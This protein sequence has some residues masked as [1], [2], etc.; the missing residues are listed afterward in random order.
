MKERINH[1]R[2]TNLGS[3]GPLFL[4]AAIV[5]YTVIV[6]A[7]YGWADSIS[8]HTDDTLTDFSDNWKIS[9]TDQEVALKHVGKYAGTDGAVTIYNYLPSSLS[10]GENLIFES[11]NVFFKVR[12]G[13]SDVYDYTSKPF[14]LAGRSYGYA[15]H[16]VG[17]GRRQAGV[18][19]EMTI[20]PAYKGAGGISEIRIGSSGT[21]MTRLFARFMPAF[22][23]SIL[24]IILGVTMLYISVGMTRLKTPLVD[25]FRMFSLTAILFGIWSLVESRIPIALTTFPDL[26]RCFTFAML[27]VLPYPAVRAANGWMIKPDPRIN[28]FF[29]GI[30]IF[31]IIFTTIVHILFGIDLWQCRLLIHASLLLAIVVMCMMSINQLIQYQRSHVHNLLREMLWGIIQLDVGCMVIDLIRYAGYGAPEDAARFTRVGF[32]LLMLVL[33]MVYKNEMVTRMK[34]SMEADLYQKLAYRDMMTGFYNRSALLEM[35]EKL[36]KEKEKGHTRDL[37]IVY[38]DLNYLKRVND[39]YGHQAGDDYICRSAHMLQQS[40]GQHGKLFRLGGDEFMAVLNGDNVYR[41]YD[42]GE[43]ALLDLLAKQ[44]HRDGRPDVSF[45]WGYAISRSDH[46]LTLEEMEKQ[47]DARMYA[48]KVEMKAERID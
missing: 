1:I 25:S 17:L 34:K 28:H 12:I 20:Y 4:T 10:Y 45:S 23:I 16:T 38:A 21:Y 15:F 24:I 40:F 7:C 8:S 6:F 41:D 5:I 46:P 47:A 43:L 29:L 31:N 33:I 26:W 13:S 22:L 30:V 19:I 2:K 18:R 35:Q 37:I 48:M 3:L 11:D 14:V 9:G 44:E 27:M 39:Q 36:E 32:V 42:D